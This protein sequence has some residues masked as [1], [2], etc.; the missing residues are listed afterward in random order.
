MRKYT[1]KRGYKG[2]RMPSLA[3]RVFW[4]GNQIF[5]ARGA[6]L[7]GTVYRDVSVKSF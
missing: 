7:P 6:D 4:K 5:F 3:T 1:I 2:Y